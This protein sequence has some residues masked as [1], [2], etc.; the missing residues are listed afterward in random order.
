MRRFALPAAFLALS[1]PALAQDMSVAIAGWT[2]EDKGGKPG[3]D[4]DRE[5]AIRKSIAHLRF[6]Y[7][8]TE[9]NTGGSFNIRFD[10]FPKCEALSFSSGFGF[11]D[12]PADRAAAVRKHVHDA[13]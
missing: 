4:A 2:L 11:D 6:S 3:D 5:V 12:P 7:S 13:F 10:D 9:T 8:P 1:T